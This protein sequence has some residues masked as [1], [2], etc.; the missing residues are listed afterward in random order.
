MKKTKKSV[1]VLL[2]I[3]IILWII[4]LAS[5]VYWMYYSVKLHREGSFDPAEYSTILRPI[6]YTCLIIA[7]VAICISFAL[8]AL[9]VKIKNER[10][11]YE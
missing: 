1:V 11:E 9:A 10:R 3:R 2:V 5:T 8:H 4:A 6:L 7:V